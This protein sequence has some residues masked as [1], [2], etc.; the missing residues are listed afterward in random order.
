[1]TGTSKKTKKQNQK[2]LAM[3]KY[4]LLLVLLVA[5]VVP[6]LAQSGP[7]GNEW[8]VPGQAYY[9]LKLARTGIYR[10]DYQYLTQAGLPAGL[11]PGLLQLWR[12]GREVAVYQGGNATALDPTTYLEFY[13]QRNDGALDADFYK[14]VA[15]QPHK[16]YSFST[17]TA[18]Y[19]IT[20]GTGPG[21]AP[22]R[23]MAQPVAAGG[24]PHPYRLLNNLKI[25][26]KHIV[27]VP[28]NSVYLPW[29]EKGEGHFSASRGGG[30]GTS[31]DSV[32][33]A[34]LPSP[35]PRLEFLFLGGNPLGHTANVETNRRVV[36]ATRNPPV[37]SYPGVRLL[38]LTPAVSGYNFTVV[39]FPL[40]RSDITPAGYFGISL[41]NPNE[42]FRLGYVRVVAPQANR[43]FRD[44]RFLLFQND[45]TLGSGP[46]TYELDSIPATVR[47][48]DVQDPWNVQRVEPTAA[49]TLGPLARR[50]VF[51]SATGQQTRSLALYDAARPLVPTPARRVTF[52]AINP[53]LANY[54]IIT[55]PKLMQPA[56]GTPNAAREFAL[57]RASAAGGRY[58][59]LLVTTP[60]LYDQFHY[61]ERSALAV[62][63]FARWLVASSAPGSTRFL[64]LLGKGI[65]PDAQIL[66]GSAFGLTET[67]STTRLAPDTGLDLVPT[68][69]RAVSD[70]W[71]S[72]DFRNNDYV[73][74]LPTG[75][76][77]ASTPQ[78]V[79]DYLAKVKAHEAL[80]LAGWRKNA[81]NI[82]GG[83]SIP[84]FG[85]FGGYQA[86]YKRLIEQP[87]FGGNVVRTIARTTVAVT[88]TSTYL[89][90]NIAAELNA[91]LSLITYFGHGSNTLFDVEIGS[92][93]NPVNNYN[94]AG[95]YPVMFYN[96]CAAS[97]LFGGYDPAPFPNNLATFGERWLFAP[98]RGA[99]G[100][101]GSTGYSY[102]TPLDTAQSVLF[103]ALLN[104][105]AWYGR[106]I[107][108]VRNE[109]AR[110][111]QASPNF[112]NSWGTIGV[113]QLLCTL[114]HGDPAL[115]L[116]A[117]ALPDFQTSN[118]QLVLEPAAGQTSVTASSATFRLNVG[119][120]N[121]GN[122]CTR[123]DSLVIKVTRRY[124]NPARPPSVVSKTFRLQPLLDAVYPLDLPNTVANGINVFGANTFNVEL[125]PVNPASGQ[126][127]ENE[128]DYGNNTAQLSY[129]FLQGGVTLL[130]PPEF[131]IVVGPQ[132]QLVAQ[133]ND[134]NGALRGY[135]FEA[136]TVPTFASPVRLQQ[137][138]L[139]AT[140][141]PRWQP[142]LPT[143]AGRD[144][145]VWY[146]RVKFTQPVGDED[147]N[148][149]LGSFR[150]VPGSP[151]GWSQSHHGQLRRDTRQGVEVSVP[152]GHWAFTTQNQPL[153]LRTVGG[154]PALA[155][156]AFPPATFQSSP[157]TGITA[158]ANNPAT[159]G[160]CGVRSPNLLAIAY[161]QRT[162][163]PL[164]I[165]GGAYN[166]CG[167]NNQNGQTFYY[168]G[169]QPVPFNAAVDTTDNLNN[170]NH[171]NGRGAAR[172][173][174]LQTWLANVPVGAYV[175]L[176]SVNRLR[177]AAW[178]AATR[179]ALSS[180]LGSV[181][182]NTLANG[183]PLVLLAQKRAPGGTG[184]TR[185]AGPN[186]AAATPRYN[187]VISL[188]DT[189][190]TPSSRG[191]VLST[192]IGPAQQWQTLYTWIQ[193][194]SPTSRYRLNIIGI[195]STG[196]AG[197][198]PL[199]T[200]VVA[201][202]S[203][204]ALGGISARRYPYLQLELTL[205]D[206]VNRQAPQLREWLVTYRGL[207][208][209][210]V[211]RD[212]V[213]AAD[214]DPATLAAQARNVGTIS[215]PVKFENVSNVDFGTP[216]KALVEL[217]DANRSN[218]VVKSAVLT[219][220]QPL[221]ANT[222]ATLPVSLNVVGVFGQLTP[223]V[224]FNP[225]PGAAPG[226]SSAL[227]ELYHFNNELVLPPF[228]ATDTNV[229]PVLDV[230]FDGRHI[231]NGEL[232][233]PTP[234][235]RIQVQDEDRLR[236]L[237]EAGSV[238]SLSL[239]GPGQPAAVPVD[240]TDTNVTF[241]VDSTSVPGSKATLVYRP[242][243]PAPLADGFYTLRVQARDRSAAAA[244]GQ[245]F[246][247]RFEVVNASTIT[248][249][250][251][252][253]NPVTSK[254][255]FVFTVTGQELPR[256]M[257]IQIMTLTGAVVREIFLAELGPL[258]IGPNL[259]DFAWDGTD[260]YGD[261]LA[262]GTYLYRVS[263]NDP[264]GQFAQR[265]T[266][267]DKAFKNDWGKLV[268]LR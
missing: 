215:F 76:V 225:L 142:A 177:Y 184:R 173:L 114:W 27:D 26:A 124:G 103:Q 99:V 96:G 261:R 100:L 218:R 178:P 120:R 237:R 75:R 145:V 197:A 74:K 151:G 253:P 176:V 78:M 146:W 163:R 10:L 19:F 29:L 122:L 190:Q 50:F 14:N 204:Y 7:Y 123:T 102:A 226:I 224:V 30:Y 207:P 167:F 85:E 21:A 138:N 65:Q 128:L 148:W 248:N 115:K 250:Y 244:G 239:Q 183:D 182:I 107:A 189:L 232:V 126:R 113:E 208:E 93:L 48:Y 136:D 39:R 16:L 66:P 263:L 119:V 2:N 234:E 212:L 46:A 62:R 3:R 36:D 210:V 195:D 60:Q 89:S 202:R 92:P 150:V 51:A 216:M 258:H 236:R 165:G 169:N 73:G 25:E 159:A 83:E 174:Q 64:L 109:A 111:L 233:S 125:N 84:D 105:P 88:G 240:V 132:P 180:Q 97:N 254:A 164:L 187:Q 249:V 209:G 91:G 211:R 22:G 192:R 252:Y 229:P 141:T 137:A 245:D 95:K 24:T 199:R 110:R 227:P 257:K 171:P 17:D 228:A 260:Q 157:G 267:G 12:R 144:S 86:H 259:T 205:A 70:A 154:G 213:A 52:R 255:R 172:H 53:A 265:A 104:E 117:P 127:R 69:T 235:I 31:M 266:A 162:L 185:E 262:N 221:A 15:D 23:R 40:L 45:S 44:R 63:H 54:I 35:A 264:N 139:Q 49:A 241:A 106:P 116:Y 82:A 156:G 193:Q 61:G 149:V 94:N 175:A 161:D 135:D 79:L 57:Y 72:C 87:C 59:T 13:G 129:N 238:F 155:A 58:D 188:Y 140:L 11:N 6:V 158:D 4:L 130:S 230:A 166:R 194:A 214:Y 43:W 81:L 243:Q 134:P 201:G 247:V 1:M 246:E 8:I 153:L 268:L 186:P 181:L 112:L 5:G 108:E 55:H 28:Q 118:A 90:V 37:I 219:L 206:S 160:D 223:R 168:F 196:A 147:P 42:F 121:P 152:G 34:I 200:A 242:G 101:L 56:T 143:F 191:Q 251:P 198:Q 98:N 47:G 77:V 131:A 256:D 20:Y 71:Y 9:K 33:R 220:P 133:T 80:G 68:S 18:A 170:P 41:F 203:G 179:Q 38:G 222:T 231:L 32:F 217:R 67:V